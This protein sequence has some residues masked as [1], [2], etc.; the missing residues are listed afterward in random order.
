MSIFVIGLGQY[1][2]LQI[3]ILFLSSYLVELLENLTKTGEYGKQKIEII[4]I[5][6]KLLFCLLKSY[7][8]FSLIL[9][10]NLKVHKLELEFFVTMKNQD[11]PAFDMLNICFLLLPIL[12]VLSHYFSHFFICFYLHCFNRFIIF[13]HGEIPIIWV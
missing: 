12:I 2:A 1:I 11:I 3:V 10:S 8:I 9:I 13:I 6:L 7:A 4:I 5:L